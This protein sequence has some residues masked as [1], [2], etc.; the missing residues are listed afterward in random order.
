MKNARL[1]FGTL[2]LILLGGLLSLPSPAIALPIS[3]ISFS[4]YSVADTAT[5]SVG[6]TPTAQS[7]TLTGPPPAG[8]QSGTVTQNNPTPSAPSSSSITAGIN[9][10]EV[11]KTYP[12][13]STSP[14][15]SI[16]QTVTA[17]S[18]APLA[19]SSSSAN[20]VFSA[21]FNGTGNLATFYVN[22]FAGGISSDPH[23]EGDGDSDFDS[24]GSNLTLTVQNM[25]TNTQIASLNVLGN[26][27][28]GGSAIINSSSGF[29]LNQY[30]N[31][32]SSTGP[33]FLDF[34]TQ[35]N[36]LYQISG[37]LQSNMGGSPATGGTGLTTFDLV[38][39]TPEPST[40]ALFG[41]GILLMGFMGLRK[42][43][44]R[45]NKA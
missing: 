36:A 34:A 31:E 43:K 23:A 22:Y 39:N 45:L 6:N 13:Q 7:Q 27:G 26:S 3:P 18:N 12:A 40:I 37:D 28:E 25:T 10:T 5:T 4:D 32:F 8:P 30:T 44:G 38:A 11:L 33:L 24:F 17:L 2:S 15:I 35:S 41:T 14:Y 20:S 19:H 29:I 42:Q 9:P 16:A 1:F 21:D